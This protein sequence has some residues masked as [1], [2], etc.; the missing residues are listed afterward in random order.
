[1][2]NE[3]HAII[4]VGFVAG[5]WAMAQT[6]KEPPNWKRLEELFLEQ[7]IKIRTET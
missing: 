4:M 1:M 7:I 6:K 5:E 3:D 2:T